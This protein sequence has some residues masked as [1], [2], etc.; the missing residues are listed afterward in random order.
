MSR[1]EKS[2]RNK[3]PTLSTSKRSMTPDKHQQI[4][5]RAQELAKIDKQL[6]PKL[7]RLHYDE[8][9]PPLQRHRNSTDFSRDYDI[10][11]FSAT[12]RSDTSAVDTNVVNKP[13]A[14]SGET[15]ESVCTNEP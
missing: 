7:L 14:S 2:D 12:E 8:K 15:E 6:V 9:V 5:E 13:G 10:D 4:L 3:V 1:D 11:T